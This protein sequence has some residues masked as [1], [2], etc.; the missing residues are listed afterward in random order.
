[1][2]ATGGIGGVHRGILPDVSADLSELA[3]TPIVVVCSGAKIVLDL[4]ATR[5]WLETHGITV[6]GYRCDEMPAFYLQHSGLSIDARAD[7]A[8]E[9]IEIINAQRA[10]EIPSALLVAVPV[11]NEA[12]VPAK[13]ISSALD[14]AIA[15]A[16]Q[17][18]IAGRELTPFLLSHMARTSDGAT[19]RTNLAL[20][21]N[22]TRVA[23]EIARL[24]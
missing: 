22:N 17:N 1:V 9:I 14:S 6:V 13:T 24:I 12:E 16:E 21:E 2:F 5:E 23:A 10:L 20:L 3:H 15:E 11:P 7:S 4:P 19:L 8:E 18:G